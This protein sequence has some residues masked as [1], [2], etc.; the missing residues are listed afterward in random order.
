ME[1]CDLDL[2]L[3][4]ICV[5]IVFNKIRYFHQFGHILFYHQNKFVTSFFVNS[6]IIFQVWFYCGYLI[7]IEFY[8]LVKKYNYF[9]CQIA[10]RQNGQSQIRFLW[11]RHKT[12]DQIWNQLWLEWREKM[13][14]TTSRIEQ[15][16][17][18]GTRCFCR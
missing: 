4:V 11:S 3:N 1:N 14:S 10:G 8:S 17:S 12:N 2:F 15:T 6:N 7:I 13:E 16:A 5:V 9:F 18:L